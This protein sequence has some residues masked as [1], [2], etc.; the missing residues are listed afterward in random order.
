MVK[1]KKDDHIFINNINLAQ[2]FMAFS[3]NSQEDATVKTKI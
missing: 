2:Y 3:K 1:E